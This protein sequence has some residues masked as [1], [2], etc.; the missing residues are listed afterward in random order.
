MVKIA[1]VDPPRAHSRPAGGPPG[2]E[3]SLSDY[4]DSIRHQ[5]NNMETQQLFN[6]TMSE[7]QLE[8]QPSRSSKLR[9]KIKKQLKFYG[10]LLGGGNKDKDSFEAYR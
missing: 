10:N 5:V 2:Q 3:S 7:N 1:P 8:E 4:D 9:L 6:K